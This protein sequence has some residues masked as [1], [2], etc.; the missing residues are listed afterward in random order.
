MQ[1]KTC[2][3]TNALGNARDCSVRAPP[4]VAPFV[5]LSTTLGGASFAEQW[6]WS[7]SPKPKPAFPTTTPQLLPGRHVLHC[8]DYLLLLLT[9][10]HRTAPVCLNVQLVGGY[11][12][13]LAGLLT[14]PTRVSAPTADFL[15]GHFAA[16][17][18]TCWSCRACLSSS[19]LCPKKRC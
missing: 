7:R 10:S 2:S 6:L 9:L 8:T 3:P 19:A 17:H 16:R 4:T 1:P 14:P 13:I 12:G 5:P 15:F 18:R 11:D